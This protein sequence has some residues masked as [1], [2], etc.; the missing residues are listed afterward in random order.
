MAEVTVAIL[1][2]GRLGTS[3][4]LALKRYNTK[5]DA[6]HKF[7]I[8]G[9][10]TIGAQGRDAQKLGA[11]D[12]TAR[13][14]G[15]AVRGRDIVVIAMPYAEVESTYDYIGQDVR[16]G[17]VVLDFSPL[18]QPSLKWAQKHLSK[19]A[20]TIGM[21]AI[22]NAKYLF[23]AVDEIERAAADLF[24]SGRMLL[25]PSVTCIPEAIELAR[26]FSAILGASPQYID[27]AENDTLI[28]VTEGLPA[29]L[30]LATYY[31]VNKSEGWTDIQK[32]ANPAFGALT[33]HLFD[34]H[35]D[36][37]RDQFLLNRENLI[38]YI[39]DLMT[40][41]KNLRRT[42][43]DNDRDALEG[44]LTNAAESYEVWYNRRRKQ[45]W[46]QDTTEK[47]QLPDMMSNLLG[48]FVTNR[49]RRGNQG[50]NKN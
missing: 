44:T 15:D 12:T 30:G 32:L 10:T 39:D 34:T 29:L 22:V 50:E 25:A 8:T 11:L 31:A 6:I 43:A 33:H 37:L 4:G 23:D 1:G 17:A 24:D 46:E 35:P 14:A 13:N 28:A 2:L 27:A 36:D 40:A 9:Y 5:P 41:L 47:P 20:H 42:L 19:D 48:G 21:T 16:A 38:R 18:K 3:I 45:Q 26:D 7:L 49:L